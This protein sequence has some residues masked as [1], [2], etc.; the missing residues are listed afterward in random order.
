MDSPDWYAVLDVR[1]DA[2]ADAIK[3]AHRRRARELHPDISSAPDATARMAELNRARD[4][5]LDTAQRSAF[6]RLREA[7]QPRRR[8]GGIG[9]FA[10][11][12]A[13][14]GAAANA[15]P[16]TGSGRMRFTFSSGDEG[17]A[18]ERE[19]R[20]A[21]H[22]PGRDAARRKSEARRW[23]FDGRAGTAQEDWYAFLNIQPWVTTTEVQAAVREL[24]TQAGDR[25]LGLDQQRSRQAKLALA[26]DTLGN[27]AKREAYDAT[28]PPWAPPPGPVADWYDLLGIRRG[29]TRDVV[30][31]AVTRLSREVG[32][33][34][35]NAD[36]RVRD[37]RLREAW[38][39]LRDPERRAA[40]DAALGEDQ[41]R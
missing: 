21:E 14:T 16:A 32:T 11:A 1:P 25:S 41:G 22:D 9:S 31:E 17:A 33:R 2:D 18:P 39:T 12:R 13:R 27:A 7:A 10:A 8:F 3:A 23:Q 6:D 35:W 34:L 19:P 20:R 40:Y 37:A 4:V 28:R 26:W 38:W 36:L 5:L 30:G 29:A 24:A 15:A